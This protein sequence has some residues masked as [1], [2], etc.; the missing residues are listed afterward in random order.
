M[1]QK[2]ILQVEPFD[3]WGIDFIG[4]FIPS[5]GNLYIFVVVDYVTKWVE[6][7]TSL[8]KDHKVLRKLLQ[9][10]IFPRFYVPRILISDGNFHF[11]KKQLEDLL[12]K[13]GVRHKGCL[14]YYPQT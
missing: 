3:V 9:H 10:N 7:I 12:A 5:F 6:A 11:A 2:I 4:P 13:Y 14:F 1:P 8:T